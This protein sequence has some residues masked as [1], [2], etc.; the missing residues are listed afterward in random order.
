[1]HIRGSVFW[2]ALWVCGCGS[3]MQATGAL[4]DETAI[5]SDYHR[6]YRRGSSILYG[7]STCMMLER[8]YE[9]SGSVLSFRGGETTPMHNLKNEQ[10]W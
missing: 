10:I 3:P 7:S 6:P 4:R 2:T 8:G 1:M 5:R 9:A